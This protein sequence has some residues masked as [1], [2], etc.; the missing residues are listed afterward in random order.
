M[1]PV[2][3]Q[4][5]VVQ[6]VQRGAVPFLCVLLT[7]MPYGTRYVFSSL[8]YTRSGLCMLLI[9][10]EKDI[11]PRLRSGY[12]DTHYVVVLGEHTH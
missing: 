3:V 11:S 4:R 7:L 9:H 12:D 2:V 1:V 10:N 8:L 5:V 6:V